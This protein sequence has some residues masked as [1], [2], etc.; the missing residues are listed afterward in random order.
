MRTWIF[1]SNPER[2]DIDGYLAANPDRCVWQVN[3]HGKEICPGDRVF[4]WK[5]SG[6][7]K[8]EVGVCAEAVV[9][10]AV[11]E[12]YDDPRARPFWLDQ[13]ESRTVRPRVELDVIRIANK[14]QILK[15]EWL[16]DDPVLGELPILRMASGTNFLVPAELQ[17]RLS[18]LWA[19]TG[20]DWTRAESVAGLWAYIRTLGGEISKKAGSP[21]AFVSEKTG[22]AISGVYNKV[23]NFRAIDP[24]DER[25]GMKGGSEMDRAV[26][27]EFYDA[28]AQMLRI[29]DV[30]AEFGRLWGAGVS[31]SSGDSTTEAQDDGQW[32]GLTLAELVEKYKNR[33]PDAKNTKPERRSTTTTQFVRDPLVVLIA[34]ERARYRCEIPACEIPGFLDRD[35]VRYCEV[36]HIQPL[37]ADGPDTPENVACLCAHHHREIHIGLDGERLTTQLKAIRMADQDA[38]MRQTIAATTE[39]VL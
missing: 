5:S 1:Q 19:R 2:F 24:R 13:A 20:E 12:R 37:A 28:Q 10:S 33:N 16:T 26:W 15:R 36:H 18:R 22:R 23:M 11:S 7:K 21:V 34:K 8:G 32:K 4:I 38:E 25:A 31:V 29:E 35:G 14:K 39:D 17:P 30:E 3:Q 27:A 6:G 9:A